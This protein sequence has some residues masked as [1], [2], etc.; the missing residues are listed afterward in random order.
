[1]ATIP[2]IPKALRDKD[3][4]RARAE[5]FGELDDEAILE[6][7]ATVKK[8]IESFTEL[9]RQAAADTVRKAE[10]DLELLEDEI[11]KRGLQPPR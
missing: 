9:H 3:K 4:R 6:Q 1:M 8:E 11:E 10:L 7:C 2:G 5:Q